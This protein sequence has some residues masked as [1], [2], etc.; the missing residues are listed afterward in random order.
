[1]QNAIQQKK[2]YQRDLEL[3]EKSL[4]LIESE[5]KN[6]A[7][8]KLLK[9]VDKFVATELKSGDL[10]REQLTKDKMFKQMAK[11]DWAKTAY[12]MP[13]NANHVKE[14]I[15]PPCKDIMC[16]YQRHKIVLKKL[17]KVKV[18]EDLTC[19]VCQKL[20]QF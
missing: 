11:A 9:E 8:L 5:K 3:Y 7:E 12:W 19:S 18:S 20:F 15:K 16:P 2:N 10:Q 14:D 6:E 17:V 1:M 4:K 13:E